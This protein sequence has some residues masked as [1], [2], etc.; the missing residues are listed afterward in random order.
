MVHR[1]GELGLVHHGFDKALLAGQVGVQDLE[2]DLSFEALNASLL[3]QINVPH[4]SRGQALQVAELTEG[5]RQI[6]A[7][8]HFHLGT[9]D[10]HSFV[11]WDQDDFLFAVAAI[12]AGR[13]LG[14][15]F[16]RQGVFG[17]TFLASDA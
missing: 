4:T 15:F 16:V 10:F 8:L 17:V 11:A 14:D 5:R 13:P 6:R 12:K 9:G 1:Y 2:D 7:V 3:G